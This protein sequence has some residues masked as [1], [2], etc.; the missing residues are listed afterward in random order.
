MAVLVAQL[1]EKSLPT[2]KVHGSNRII[3]KIHIAHLLAVNC[4][5]KM[6]IKKWESENV[7]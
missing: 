3:G 4:F 5:E 7:H 2:P 1:V 6:K